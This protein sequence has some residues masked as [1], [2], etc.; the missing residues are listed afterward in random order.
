MANEQQLMIN[1]ARR[2]LED[3]QR[4]LQPGTEV[5]VDLGKVLAELDALARRGKGILPG[6]LIH[7]LERRSYQKACALL[8]IGS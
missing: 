7:Y 6:D 2:L 8:G 1:D 4:S 5:S 3:F